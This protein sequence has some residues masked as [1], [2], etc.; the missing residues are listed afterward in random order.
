M[1]ILFAAITVLIA[2][3][4]SAEARTHHHRHYA[5]PA[6]H[7]RHYVD[8]HRTNRLARVERSRVVNQ[9]QFAGF[10]VFA[11]QNVASLS[12]GRVRRS[13]PSRYRSANTSYRYANNGYHHAPG[14]RP[15][16]WCGWY[17]RTLVGADPGP[18]Y[19]LARSWAHYGSNAGGPSVGTIVVWAHHV[20]KIVGQENGQWIV[21]SGNDGHAV[22]AR[23]R[24]LAGAIAF[25]SAYAS[26]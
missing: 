3:A 24:S 19:N 26:M 17:M 1:R 7:Q 5:H 6:H 14:G 11:D 23:P 10:G 21:E 12:D 4:S 22:R 2:F 8:Q 20:G 13:A 15:A 16:A 25:R 9:Q 18:Q